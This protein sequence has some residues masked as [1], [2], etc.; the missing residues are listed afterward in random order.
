MATRIRQIL[1]DDDVL[2]RLGGD[3]FTVLLRGLR[4]EREALAMAHRIHS[5]FETPFVINDHRILVTASV[6]VTIQRD[7]TERPQ[8]LLSQADTAQYHAKENGRNRVEVF[9]P[10]LRPIFRRRLDHEK[11]LRQALVE[12]QIVAYFQPQVDLA[13]GRIVGAEALARWD[14]P[15]PRGA[16]GGRFRTP[17]RGDRPHPGDRRR[18][19]PQRHRGPDRAGRGR[20]RS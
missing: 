16:D 19:P 5:S 17:G 7:L 14:H 20:L 10:T 2:A 12:G 8:D 11:A 4:D 15:T 9:V 18:R 3:E 6:G 1:R 13:T